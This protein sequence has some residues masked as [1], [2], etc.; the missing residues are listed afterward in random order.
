KY[1]R[2]TVPMTVIPSKAMKALINLVLDSDTG[3]PR[4]AKKWYCLP[5]GAS[6]NVV[7][8][9]HNGIIFCHEIRNYH[10]P[11]CKIYRI[12]QELFCAAAHPLAKLDSCTS[13]TLCGE[14]YE[15]LERFVFQQ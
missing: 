3:L 15:T 1:I 11:V 2:P 7:R 12:A 14:H 9:V 6:A 13:L 10:N 8:P 4:F 5:T